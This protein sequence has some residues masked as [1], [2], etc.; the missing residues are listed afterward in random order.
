M[1]SRKVKFVVYVN[2]MLIG[3]NI[4]IKYGDQNGHILFNKPF[5]WLMD[6]NLSM[7]GGHHNFDGFCIY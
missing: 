6:Q 4:V 7:K 5:I 2:V 3:V 1:Y